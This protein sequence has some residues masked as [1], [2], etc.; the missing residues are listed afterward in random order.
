MFFQQ[1]RQHIIGGLGRWDYSSDRDI[2]YN[3]LAQS[4]GLKKGKRRHVNV[5]A[6]EVYALLNA[7][8]ITDNYTSIVDN[9]HYDAPDDE[10]FDRY[11][12]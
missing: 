7:I 11:F 3:E 9:N 5:K 8:Y 1:T 4:K 6:Q 12:V 10:H 2:T